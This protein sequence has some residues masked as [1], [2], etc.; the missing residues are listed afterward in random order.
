M[1][2][3]I[4]APESMIEFC[5]SPEAKSKPYDICLHC[6]Y[7]KESC[8][9]PNIL[10]MEYP[11]WAEWARE[12][13]KRLGLSKADVAEAAGLSP[14]TLNGAL[15]GAGYDIRTDTMRR[16]TKAIIG[17]SWGQYP[18]HVAAVLIDGGG[19]EENESSQKIADLQAE[20]DRLNAELK[21][22]ISSA[23]A[24]VQDAKQESQ[25]KI[26][27]LKDQVTIRDKYLA[28]KNQMITDLMN[29]ILKEKG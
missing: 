20:I 22:V 4:N 25:A 9:G 10:A 17:G 23:E 13:I 28:E 11:R 14:S 26:D 8:D 6:P 21:R 7:I 29:A 5:H 27:Y 2:I 12:R 1:K 24:K 15:S 3:T 19:E 18:C 16:I